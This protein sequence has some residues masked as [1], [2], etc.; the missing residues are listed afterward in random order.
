[1]AEERRDGPGTK[2]H[3]LV[4]RTSRQ[5]RTQPR[6]R[7]IFD[8]PELQLHGAHVLLVQRLVHGVDENHATP[9]EQQLPHRSRRAVHHF[10]AQ[11]AGG[12]RPG[13]LA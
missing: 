3:E 5:P 1:M 8:R 13:C 4:E 7:H 2:S 9:R 10:V 12:N 6:R 11:K